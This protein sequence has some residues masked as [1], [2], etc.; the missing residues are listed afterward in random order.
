MGSKSGIN[1]LLSLPAV[2]EGRLHR[3]T[4]R[5]SVD[6]QAVT[7]GLVGEGSEKV[8]HPKRRI[9]TLSQEL[10]G[11]RKVTLLFSTLLHPAQPRPGEGEFNLQRPGVAI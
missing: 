4:L 6:E 10:E 7:D 9:F 8:E 1:N 5:D 3:L 11:N 2:K